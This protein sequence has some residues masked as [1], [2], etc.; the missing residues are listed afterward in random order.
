MKDIRVAI[1]AGLGCLCVSAILNADTLVLRD[2]RRVDGDLVAVHEGVVEFDAQ[3]SGFFGGREHLRVDRDEVVRIELDDRAARARERDADAGRDRAADADAGRERDQ[4][5][6]PS[7]LRERDVT[8]DAATA[9]RDTGIDLRAG[10]TVYFSAS[11]RVRWGPNRQDGPEGEHGS[12]YNAGRPIPGRPAAALVG[13]VGEGSD[14][15]FI[16]D[17]KGPV[18]VRAS[19]RLYLGINDDFLKDNSGSFRVTVYY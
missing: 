3:R 19:G 9:W 7:G 8:V 17:D 5:E 4:R 6:R 1:A 18:R 15:F 2:G 14:N 12:P 16:G 11:G 13:R 10:Q